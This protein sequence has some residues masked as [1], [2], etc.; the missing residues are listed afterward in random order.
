[1][2]LASMDADR[3]AR[4][5]LTACKY[6]RAELTLSLPAKLAVAIDALAPELT[7]DV[8]TFAEHFLPRTGGIG[9]ASAEGK[10]STSAWSPSVLTAL[11]ERAAVDNNQILPDEVPPHVA[12]TAAPGAASRTR[13]EP[14]C[15]MVDEA[16]EQSFPA[17]DP[18]SR[19]P[20][21]SV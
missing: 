21:T 10:Y 8:T 16:S 19:T 4:K 9:R 3:A 2:P 5:I 13:M 20:V 6:G 12:S 14:A 15:D 18:P 1:M 7:A 17:S 11:N